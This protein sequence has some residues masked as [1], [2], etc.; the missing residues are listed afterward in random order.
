MVFQ[1]PTNMCSHYRTFG[2]ATMATV[3][4]HDGLIQTAYP[5]QLGSHNSVMP[6]THSRPL[7]PFQGI[8]YFNMP[9]SNTYENMAHSNQ[10]VPQ[11]RG[12]PTIKD[13]L[14]SDSQ[15]PMSTEYAQPPHFTFYNHH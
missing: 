1:P 6:L 2:N 3:L 5:Q 12:L 13:T 14:F 9:F 15:L 7:L 10:L 4:P 11:A 8:E